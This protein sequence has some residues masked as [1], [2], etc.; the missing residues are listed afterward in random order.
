[1]KTTN[2]RDILTL[3]KGYQATYIWATIFL[4]L[5]SGLG[6]IVPL[7]GKITIDGILGGNTDEIP[8]IALKVIQWL[9]G[10]NLISQ[11]L[12][13]AGI[14]LMVVSFASALFLYLRD[15]FTALTCEKIAKNL[16]NQLY[17]HLHH[18]TSDYHSKAQTGDLIQRCSS[19]VETVKIFLSKQ[20][21]AIGRAIILLVLVIPLMLSLNIPLTFL[22]LFMVPVLILFSVL[23]FN[24]VKKVFLEVEV[25]EGSLT[26][27]IQENLT[28]IR[29]V[30]AFARQDFEIEK[31]TRFNKIY[32]DIE[33]RLINILSWFWC[34]TDL[35][36]VFQ[37]GIVLFGG[38]WLVMQGRITIGVLFAF[39]TYTGMVLWPI[40]HMGRILADTGKAIVAYGRIREILDEPVETDNNFLPKH[41]PRRLTGEIEFRNVSFFYHANQLA[42]DNFTCFIKPGSTVSIIGPTGSGKS[43]LL[44]LLLRLYDYQQGSILVDG[45]ELNQICRKEIRQQIG[46]ALQEPFLF[47][48]T[49]RENIKFSQLKANDKAVENAAHTACVHDAITAFKKGYETHIGEKGVTLSGGQV[50]R[51]A[52]SRTLLK[53]PPIL[54]LD[55]TFSA[56]DTHTE[57]KILAT[58]KQRFQKKT[59]LIVTHRLSCCL[60]SD[61]IIV[62]D[63][64][65]IVQKGTHEELR[66]LEGFYQDVWNIQR[67]LNKEIS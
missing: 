34:T 17:D 56:V 10:Q 41:F 4:I 52:L 54:V 58:L 14:L 18:V 23:F 55:D 40:R 2:Y 45:F 1:M 30:R 33:F 3:I 24:K 26:T 53:D 25:A 21:T 36:C 48:R 66:E 22:S 44:K 11:N 64:G 8:T 38:S 37:L 28:G 7:I 12:W 5:S 13:F 46:T 59:T 27:V 61:Q 32:K 39:I 50:Q 6:F 43:T 31:F 65:K 35:I 29:V 62:M 49:V 47:A 57:Q 67:E 42:L 63:K 16:R 20:I 51:V 9:G 60:Q 15:R 19:D